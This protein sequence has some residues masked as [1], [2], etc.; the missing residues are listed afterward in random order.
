MTKNVQDKGTTAGA[1]CDSSLDLYNEGAAG[2]KIA[3]R[4]KCEELQT[5]QSKNGNEGRTEE[6]QSVKNI[7]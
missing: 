1:A 7:R 4:T 2:G 5:S 6:E 3:K